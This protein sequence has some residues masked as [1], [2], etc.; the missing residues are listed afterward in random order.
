ML[1]E[2]RAHPSDRHTIFQT[3]NIHLWLLFF[4]TGSRGLG[5]LREGNS[6]EVSDP[7]I[8]NCFAILY[9]DHSA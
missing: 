6:H 8:H 5:I 7:H 1:T 2:I 9:S 3:S 4:Q